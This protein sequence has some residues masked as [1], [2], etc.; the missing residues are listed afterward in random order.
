[1]MSR[2][3]RTSAA[4]ACAGVAL[5][6]LMAGCGGM[7]VRVSDATTGAG[8]SGARIAR[9]LAGSTDA[10]T[11]SDGRASMTDTAPD[12]LLAVRAD[13]YRPWFGTRSE[14]TAADGTLAVAL[15]PAWLDAFMDGRAHPRGQID[16]D[17]TPKPCNCP[18][19]GR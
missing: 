15:S 11:G 10:V 14:A 17:G 8:I 4:R 5:L 3:S 19:H 7:A 9:G 1:M 2:W 13:G 6:V 16:P 18:G 12:A